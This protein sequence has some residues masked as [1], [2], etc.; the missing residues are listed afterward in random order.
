MYTFQFGWARWVFLFGKFVKSV[1][2][3]DDQILS[4][5]LSMGAILT[6]QSQIETNM[7]PI[8]GFD[9]PLD[10]NRVQRKGSDLASF[11]MFRTL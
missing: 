5:T 10:A 1:L 4:I 9:Y 8:H 3:K 7:L 2:E 11:W 6:S